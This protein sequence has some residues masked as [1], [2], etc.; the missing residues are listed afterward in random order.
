MYHSL[1]C[2]FFFWIVLKDPCFVTCNHL[3]Q[4]ISVTLD[5]FQKMKTQSFRLSFC[6]IVRF[7]GTIFAHNFFMA[8]SSV[9]IW[10]TVV[11]FKF[12]SLSIIRTVSRRSDKGSHYLHIVI[13][14][15]SWRSSRA[16]FIFNGFT[17]LIPLE[18]LWSRQNMLPIGLFQFIESFNAGFPK[19]DTKLDCTSLLEI[20]LFHF[21]DTHTKTASQETALKLACWPYRVETH[22]RSLWG[23]YLT[24]I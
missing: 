5:P 11:W 24:F 15:W 17:A 10:W 6:S 20:A 9:K 7:L 12:N 3:L 19:F 18:L 16:G 1:L 8:N 4:D 23:S 2:L 14:F 22:T 21:R 13:S